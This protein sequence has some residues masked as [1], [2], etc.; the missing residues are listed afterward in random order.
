MLHMT[1]SCTNLKSLAVF[2]AEIFQGAA[3]G[4]LDQLTVSRPG[5]AELPS[6][7]SDHFWLVYMQH[8]CRQGGKCTN[9]LSAT[10]APAKLLST[11]SDH[12]FSQHMS[13][14]LPT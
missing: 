4:R 7:L 11:L 9:L 13:A 6:P 12:F 8:I 3:G 14:Y 10:P 1:N 2:V 5:S